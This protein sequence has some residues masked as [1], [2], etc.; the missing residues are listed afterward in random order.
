MA[1]TQIL[2]IFKKF[3]VFDIAPSSNVRTIFTHNQMGENC[4]FTP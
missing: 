2:Y 4:G 3:G 1:E